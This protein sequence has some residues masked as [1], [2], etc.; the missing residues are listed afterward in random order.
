MAELTTTLLSPVILFFVLGA[1]AAF[2]RSDLDVPEQVAKGLSL[3]L[4]AAIG[5]KGGL[6]VSKAGFETQMLSVGL[7]G[8]V[9]SFALPFLGYVLLRA[10]AHLDPLNA[11]AVAAHY[12]SVSVVTFVTGVAVLESDGIG[13]AGWMVAVLALM[14][15]PAIISGLV[16]ARGTLGNIG[17]TRNVEGFGEHSIWREVLLNGPVVLLVG[18]FAIGLIAGPAGYAPVAP[19]F[20]DLFRGALCLFLLSMGLLAARRLREA[21]NLKPVHV[22]LAVVIPLINA[23][24]GLAV[25]FLLGLPPGTGAAFMILCASASYIA[26]P[27]AMQLAL[28]R[29]DAGLYLAMSLAITFPFNIIVGIPLYAGIAERLL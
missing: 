23:A 24:V 3:Y 7:A 20:T 9:L 25:A 17:R 15:T 27:A 22:M 11:G 10:L 29:A 14:E 8:L 4:M 6:E 2:A 19:L 5:L 1:A 18:A 26:V 13:P 21:R 12:G 16:L 28:P